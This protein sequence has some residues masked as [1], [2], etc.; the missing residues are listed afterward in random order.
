MKNVSRG[1]PQ[2]GTDLGVVFQN[3]VR[4]RIPRPS[5]STQLLVEVGKLGSHF[6]CILQVILDELNGRTKL[7]L[8]KR[9]I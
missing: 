6:G 5:R 2:L 7:M 3:L 4:F 1:S 8:K 9:T